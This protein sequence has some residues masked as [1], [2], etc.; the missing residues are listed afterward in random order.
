VVHLINSKTIIIKKADQVGNILLVKIQRM[1]A[2]FFS[3]WNLSVIKWFQKE[4]QSAGMAWAGEL[5]ALYRQEKY[6]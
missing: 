3:T 1:K 2:R 5:L 4:L 6:D